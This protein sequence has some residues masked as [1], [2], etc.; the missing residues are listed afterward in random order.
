M[1]NLFR[2]DI[3]ALMKIGVDI[4]CLTEGRRTGVEEYTLNLLDNLFRID[5]KNEYV[6]FFNSWKDPQADFS[7]M[8]KYL[9][10]TLK[11]FSIPNKILNFSFWYFG[12]PKID[13]MIGGADVIFLPN[14][15]FGAVSKRAR[16]V[17]TMHDLSFERYPET[18]SWKRRLWHVFIN[19][20]K[21]CAR[22]DKI[23]AVSDSTRNDLV[24]LYKID[25]KKIKTIHSGVADKFKVI[26]R[27]DEKLIAA[28]DKYKLPY[29]FILYLGTI[30]PR[31]NIEGIIQAYDQLRKTAELSDYKLIIAGSAGWLSKK[32]FSAIGNSEFRGDIKA[33]NFIDDADKPYVYNLASLFIYPSLFEGF[34]F[35]VLEAMAC[36]IPVI[37]SNNSS[38][39]EI[40]GGASILI[41]PDKPQEIAIAMREILAN[42]E[43]KAKLIEKGLARSKQFNWQKTA[44]ITLDALTRHK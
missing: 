1:L 40:A 11:R 29:K 17:V 8:N 6:L 23:I 20:K 37:T 4:R 28:K 35:P 27:N 9:N 25:P 26:S 44:K 42:Q 5:K 7:W 16:L 21:I 36:G 13:K 15:I 14:I 30:E 32:I 24:D 41:D 22:A 3:R 12:W 10:V 38:L 43:L 2:D 19:P 18:F 33:I 39:P 31:K 34:G